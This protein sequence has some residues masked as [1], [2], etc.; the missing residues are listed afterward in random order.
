MGVIPSMSS[1][2]FVTCAMRS[3]CNWSG[4][5]RGVSPHSLHERPAI[6][7]PQS[8]CRIQYGCSCCVLGVTGGGVPQPKTASTIPNREHVVISHGLNTQTRRRSRF[9]TR[10]NTMFP[11]RH[12][13]RCASKAS[14]NNDWYKPKRWARAIRTRSHACAGLPIKRMTHLNAPTLPHSSASASPSLQ[15]IQS[16]SDQVSLLLIVDQ[17]SACVFTMTQS[18][19]QH[20]PDARLDPRRQHGGMR[21]H[22]GADRHN[23]ISIVCRNLKN[24]KKFSGL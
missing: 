8:L 11:P 2:G 23:P 14:S 17:Q 7:G 22:R 16:R 24:T 13:K 6:F 19:P 12:P 20:L 1:C 4:W 3:S 5:D 15:P 21:R 18:A 10:W 9:A